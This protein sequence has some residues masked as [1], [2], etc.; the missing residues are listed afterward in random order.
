MVAGQRP[1]SRVP[2]SVLACLAVAVALQVGIRAAGPR[3]T[4]V[5]AHLAAP[6]PLTVLKSAA[7]GEPI[8][9]AQLLTLYLQ[10]FDT[11]PGVSIPFKDLDY[12]RTVSW[13][14]A[15]L[16]LDPPG[17]YPLLLA[18]QVYSQVPDPH[19]QRQMVE[20]VYRQ[21]EL[22]PVRRWRWLAHCVLVAKHRLK[23]LPLALRYAQA[24]A[25]RGT[26]PSIPGWAR[27]MH[28]FLLEDLGEYESARL[29]LGGLL[30][31]GSVSDPNETRFLMERLKALQNVE[32]STAA[33]N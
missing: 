33:P 24:L 32:K 9:F 22:D 10:A 30:T 11:Q 1:L 12:G 21:F 3:P 31:S 5:A 4:A 27:Q 28:I 6:P 23:D 29:L 15:V 14:D 16:A 19:K 8:A 7:F 18:A 26:D 13:L 2:A 25:Q 17:Q 20:F